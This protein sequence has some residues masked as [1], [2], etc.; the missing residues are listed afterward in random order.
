MR[1]VTIC[2][3]GLCQ[4]TDCGCSGIYTVFDELLRD[5]AQVH[6]DLTGLN[7]VYLA[8]AGQYGTPESM[9]SKSNYALNEP[10]WLG[11][12]PFS[13]HCVCRRAKSASARVALNA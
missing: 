7:L 12:L 10:R 11:S 8:G 13:F 4:L 6:N 9:T 1:P 2:L 5:R 3:F